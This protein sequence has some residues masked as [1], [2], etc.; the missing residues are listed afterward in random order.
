[1]RL[2]LTLASVVVVAVT[3]LSCVT[4]AQ[5]EEASASASPPAEEV[6]H[7]TTAARTGAAI[8]YYVRSDGG[9]LTQCTGLADAPYPGSGAGQPCAWDHPFRALPPDS[10]PIIGG[11]DTLII[12]P[13]SYRM[14]HGAHGA[15]ACETDYPWDCHM[16]PIPSGPDAANPTRIL[17]AGWDTG[18]TNPPELWGAERAGMVLNLTDASHVEI[19]CLEITDHSGCVEFHSGGLACER[20]SYPFGDWAVDGLYAEDSTGVYL[21]GLDIHGLAASGVRAGRLTDWTVENVRVAGNGWVGWEGDIDGGDSNAGTLL[22]RRWTVEWNGCAESYPGGEPTGCWA[23]TAGGYGDGVGTGA[24]GGDWII[25]DSAFLHNTSDGLDLLYHELGGSVTLDRV[26]AEGNAGNQVKITGQTVITNSV[27]VGNCA[28]FE[29]QPFTHNVDACRALGNTLEIVYT[30]G[31]QATI[32]NTT[33]YGHGDG[34]LGSG[35]R[36]GHTCDGTETLAVRNSI[37]RGDADYFSPGDV[38]FL[39]Y[40]EGCGDLTLDSDYNVAH[41]VKNITCGASG[42]YVNSGS[43]DLCQDPL[44]VGPLSGSSFWMELATESPAID[45]GDNTVCPAVDYLGIARPADGDEDGAPV[46]DVGA[47]EFQALP[48]QGFLP[49]VAGGHR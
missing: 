25:E 8:T 39:F 43:H 41:S 44:L 5:E 10:T 29:G 21:H 40:Q 13:G 28:F 12:G 24:T 20:D 36:E 9:S 14:G 1:M 38:T 42:T 17:G 2:K 11:G 19:G 37:F 31:E 32:V 45:A 4:M 6:M 30:G 35:P 47:Y 33:F 23:Q 18:C 22:F 27:L 16:P 15:G 48:A 34:L 49:L 46:C 3:G 7:P 26:R